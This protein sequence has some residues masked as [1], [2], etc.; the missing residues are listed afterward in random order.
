MKIYS[1]LLITFVSLIC[2]SNCGKEP[3][4]T[5]PVSGIDENPLFNKDIQPIFNT[6]CSVSNCHNS[7][8]AA[9]LNLSE[10]VARDFLVDQTSKQVSDTKLVIPGNTEN[11]Y[12]I[13][14]LENRQTNGTSRMPLGA[15]ALSTETI[16]LIKNWISKGA[17]DN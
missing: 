12:L 8:A 17:Q 15:S 13:I 1:I 7:S 16:Q 4:P 10:N 2:L 14:K 6:N 9:G 3:C 11:S 5:E